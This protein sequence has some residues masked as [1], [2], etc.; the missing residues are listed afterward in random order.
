[1]HAIS[2]CDSTSRFFKIGKQTA[3]K[4][5][6]RHQDELKGLTEFQSPDQETGMNSARKFGILMYKSRKDRLCS[7]LDELRLIQSSTTDKP[8]ASL[9]PTEDAFHQHARRA[10]YQTMIWCSSHIAKP[11]LGNPSEYG[12]TKSGDNLVCIRTSKESAPSELRNITH[13]YCQDTSCIDGAKCPCLQVGL[14]CIDACKCSDCPNT[15]RIEQDNADGDG[16]G[17]CNES[18]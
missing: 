11:V 9:P 13:L 12:W 1:M 6:Q 15:V 10:K 2:G 8:V 18:C 14:P 16:D 3:Y 5:L 4:M 7:T 17:N